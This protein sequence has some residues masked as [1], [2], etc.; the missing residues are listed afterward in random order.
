MAS[1]EGDR[2]RAMP[3]GG[4]GDVQGGMALAGGIAAALYGRSL[5]GVGALVDVSLLGVG[6]WDV[7]EV[8]QVADV[9]KIDPKTEFKPGAIPINP[10][11]GVYATRDGRDIALCMIQSDPYWPGF[12]AALELS[13]LEADPRF[14]SFEARAD[15]REALRTIIVDF[16]ATH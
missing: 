13:H 1:P 5:S 15:N 2:A 7:Y 8:L 14:A 11:T 4:F 16:F 10:L 9:Y 6:L 12:C 3:A